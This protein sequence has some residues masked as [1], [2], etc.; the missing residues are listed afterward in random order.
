MLVLINNHSCSPGQLTKTQSYWAQIYFYFSFKS[1][2]PKIAVFVWAEVA[3]S[4]PLSL[5]S[6]SPFHPITTC[7]TLLQPIICQLSNFKMFLSYCC[8]FSSVKTLWPFTTSTLRAEL[9]LHQ[10]LISSTSVEVLRD[11][12]DCLPCWPT[13][14]RH[15]SDT[16]DSRCIEAKWRDF[17][18]CLV[19]SVLLIETSFQS[20]PIIIKCHIYEYTVEEEKKTW[21]VN[22]S[23]FFYST[24]S[25]RA[26]VSGW[27]TEEHK[28]RRNNGSYNVAAECL[29]AGK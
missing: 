23:L 21:T 5:I 1:P 17:W 26:S 20:E 29:W 6:P 3:S 22:S 9:P 13:S 24:C 8:Y 28:Q 18:R 15:L 25:A 16:V 2:S 11:S 19:V 27:C 14:C 10:L 12:A 7:H 4:F